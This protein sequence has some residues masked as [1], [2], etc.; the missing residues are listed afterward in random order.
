MAIDI[1]NLVAQ[2][3]LEEKISFLAGKSTWRTAEVDRIGIPNIKLSDGPSGARGEIFGEGVPA[4]FLPSGVSL[5]A[6]WDVNI[7]REMG[8]LLAEETKSKSASVLL[9]PTICLARN[10]LGGR[11]FEAYGDDP[12]HS[13]KLATALVQGIQSQGIGATLKHYVGNDSE[14]DRFH[15]NRVIPTRALRECYLKPFQMAVR[16]ADPWC[17][18]TAYN[19]VNDHHC[20]SSRELLTDIARKE[21]GWN[22][23]FMS[24]WGGTTSVGPSIQAGLD[25]EMPGP[26][27]KRTLE[28]VM[29]LI[30][31]GEVEISQIDE[32]A[33]HLLG[34]L[35]RSGRFEN[36]TDNGE[37]CLN[38]PEQ[39]AKLRH[40]A[41]AG[42]VLL[43]NENNA[44]PIRPN[45]EFKKIAIVGPNGERIVAGGGGSS[46]IKAPYWTS[47]LNSIKDRFG[48]C[49]TEI[50]HHS[51]AQVNRYVPTSPST[52]CR[53][54]DTGIGGGAVDWRHGHE[55]D[56]LYFMSFG[57]RPREI[58]NDYDF[59]FAVRTILKPKTTGLHRVSLASIG[60]SKLYVDGKEVL[61]E[62]GELREDATL[63]FT[64][65]S[66]ETI[67]DIHLNEGQE[68]QIRINGH[69]HDRQLDRSLDE[70][71]RPMENKFAGIRF[72]YQEFETSDL[73][74]E[75]AQ[76]CRDSDVSIV[77][78]GRDKEWETEGQDIPQFEL[79]GEQC[80]LI[81]EVAN[82]CPRTI[83]VVQAGTP[84]KLE[85]W[86]H[87][88]QGLLYTWY[89]G[90][91]L[92]NAAA[93]VLCGLFNPSG[94]LP[95]VYPQ[96]I[97]HSP[98]T[99]NPLE[100]GAD[101]SSLYAEG[102][103]IGHRYL[104]FLRLE[105]MFPLGYGLSYS[106][107]ELK[108]VKI[109]RSLL[110]P[111]QSLKVQLRVKNTGG[112][113]IPTAETILAFFSP[114]SPPPLSMPLKT[115]CGF[116]KTPKL[117]TAQECEV[118]ID[119]D[120]YSMGIYDPLL[121]QWI[122]P[123]GVKFDILVGKNSRDASWVGQVEV[124]QTIT[125]V[126]RITSDSTK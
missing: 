87:K 123:S 75:A 34:L 61:S 47:V 110:T 6:T 62:G 66:P 51:G 86:I 96:R 88:V 114:A 118:E 111:E 50:A 27:S 1:D 59:N 4:A 2:L 64:Y 11:N 20:D 38:K 15:G 3:T 112:N 73:P 9:S 18:M 43:K 28:A 14:L 76:V 74:S 83:V 58:P 79:P 82:V 84:V 78:V 101:T 24:D 63:F 91:E 36:P 117:Q 60:P 122:V 16:D 113:E 23:L 46:Y 45:D 37:V 44:L 57:D 33:R 119:I 72:G 85:P 8:E 80:R 10:P 26:P 102:I 25:L 52:Q 109:A 120:A 29:A 41:S 40:A 108:D 22:G 94:R 115:L 39:A 97:E 32:S 69:S 54:P 125:W 48:G 103:H 55:H 77:V 5:G 42:I 31:A 93:D 89:Q 98:G 19:K 53:D 35:E 124:Q 116:T 90:Q 95:V 13:G 92:G 65:G 30:K 70:R 106:S 99:M 56:D 107:F 17:M 81:E 104:D 49:K 67:C 100:P 68:Y 126:H 7:L 105:P 121:K 71:I 21:W 12:F